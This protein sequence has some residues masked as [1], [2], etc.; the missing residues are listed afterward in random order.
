[1]TSLSLIAAIDDDM[2]IGLDGSL[3]WDIQG[4]LGHFRRLTLGHVVIMGGRTYRGLP[5]RMDKR[6]VIVVSRAP[7]VAGARRAS[8]PEEAVRI[9]ARF[10]TEVFVAGGGEIYSALLPHCSTA[11]LTR[12]P[13]THGCDTR[14]EG[15]D[16]AKWCLIS[17]RTSDACRW[18]EW[19]RIGS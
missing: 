6:E 15:F 12:V 5:R 18:Q 3:P 10:K 8:S 1:M 11:Y 16:F 19:R 9:A 14:L 13:G 7:V 2:G 17:E 4:D